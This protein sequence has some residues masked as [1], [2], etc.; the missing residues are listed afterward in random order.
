[1]ARRP[2]RTLVELLIPLAALVAVLVPSSA[3]AAAAWTAIR[4]T[5]VDGLSPLVTLLA[6]LLL[7]A[8]LAGQLILL[9]LVAAWR[10]AVWTVEV[11]GTFGGVADRREGDW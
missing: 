5:L 1:M 2:L 3:A 10:G 11:A 9:G 8:V 4:T 6:V 7:V